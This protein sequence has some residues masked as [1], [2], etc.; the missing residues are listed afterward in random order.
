M[1][2]L[3]RAAVHLDTLAGLSEAAGFALGAALFAQ[4][5]EMLLRAA[6]AAFGHRLMMDAVAPGG[7]AM[8]IAPEG[9]AA[10]LAALTGLA[11]VGALYRGPLAERLAGLGRADT[12]ALAPGGVAGRAAGQPG[13]SRVS[14]G[15]PPYDGM[16]VT[17]P[18]LAAGDADARA[19]I[20][21]LEIE[22]SVGLL[23]R[24]LTGLPPGAVSVALPSSSG[25]GLGVAES[26]RGAV[27]HWLRLDGG[28][29]AAAF[30][31]DPGWRLFPLAELALAD[32]GVGDVELIL[33]SFAASASAVDL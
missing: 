32:G 15:Y 5:R 33:R 19:K 20:R 22:E 2:E 29:I 23:Q 21:V 31:A 1:A 6:E 12:V 17:A 27:W 4:Q 3:E 24:L 7:V 11:E 18:V 8:D 30:A 14:P 10:I 9:V 26:P 13:D 25:E 16:S 28:M